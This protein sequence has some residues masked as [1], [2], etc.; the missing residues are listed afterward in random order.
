VAK[1]KM[2][3]SLVHKKKKKTRKK[4]HRERIHEAGL[5]VK[6]PQSVPL[7]SGPYRM[8]DIRDPFCFPY[9]TRPFFHP[10]I[11]ARYRSVA[12]PRGSPPHGTSHQWRQTSAQRLVP[13]RYLL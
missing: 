2:T 11:R 9:W 10:V 5:A 1:A 8:A 13:R 6:A 7:M 3:L 12:C 4:N